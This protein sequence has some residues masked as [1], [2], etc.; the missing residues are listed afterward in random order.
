[1]KTYNLIDH[2]I[3][4]FVAIFFQQSTEHMFSLFQQFLQRV[5]PSSIIPAPYQP[6]ASPAGVPQQQGF[7]PQEGS[8]VMMQQEQ[9]SFV[10]YLPGTVVHGGGHQHLMQQGQTTFGQGHLTTMV[11]G[12]RPQQLTMVHQGQPS[13]GL[14]QPAPMHHHLG[15]VPAPQQ[16]LQQGGQTSSMMP[17]HHQA[18]QPAAQQPHYQGGQAAPMMTMHHQASQPAAQEPHYQGAQAAPMLTMHHQGSS[19]PGAHHQHGQP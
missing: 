1:M 13:F 17:M 15:Q 9:P 6:M 14:L 5:T 11:P 3:F 10:P 2:L 16:V 8:Q 18:S 4:D 7:M 12:G 19:Q